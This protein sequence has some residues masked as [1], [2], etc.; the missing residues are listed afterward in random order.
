M[1]SDAVQEGGV[2]GVGGVSGEGGVGGRSVPDQEGCVGGV[3]GRSV[4][5]R[6]RLDGKAALVTG[7]GQVSSTAPRHLCC[8]VESRVSAVLL[9]HP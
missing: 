5:D 1:A 8:T 7:G 9:Y 3:G 6:L 2:G 4:L